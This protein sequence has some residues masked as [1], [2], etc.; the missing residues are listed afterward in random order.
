MPELT[1]AHRMEA[2]RVIT[3][4]GFPPPAD[5]VARGR[6]LELV[7]AL[8]TAIA[9]AEQRGPVS[10]PTVVPT[11]AADRV[12]AFLA[13]R[14]GAAA[15]LDQELI[16]AHNR[17]ELRA[18][19][20]RALVSAATARPNTPTERLR[21]ALAEVLAQYDVACDDWTQANTDQNEAPDP[22]TAMR[23]SDRLE[24]AAHRFAALLRPALEETP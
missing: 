13:A 24:T 5:L 8:A 3:V 11:A 12:E 17:Q 23:Y 20:L 6:R 1:D 16:H 18:S 7:D 10:V 15:G 22:S 14:S 19:D 21:A 2:R 4:A 9:G